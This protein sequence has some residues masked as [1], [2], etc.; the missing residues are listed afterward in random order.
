MNL[1]RK[2]NAFDA[3]KF[4]KKADYG[5]KNKEIETKIPNHNK[6]ITINYSNKFSS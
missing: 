5:K 6:Y 1:L 2:R 4:V 3:S